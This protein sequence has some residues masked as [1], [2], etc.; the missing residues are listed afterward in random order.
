VALW[1]YVKHGRR[2]SIP[3][4]ERMSEPDSEKLP[5][6]N[7]LSKAVSHCGAGCTLGD[8]AGEWT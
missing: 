5:R 1:F 6:W 8:I 2:T 4:I 3:M 7:I